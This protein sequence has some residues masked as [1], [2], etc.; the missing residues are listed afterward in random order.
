MQT[1][2]KP[3]VLAQRIPQQ[4]KL[5]KEW[6]VLCSRATSS[7]EE[8]EEEEEKEARWIAES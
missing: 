5:V 1:T 4:E 8:E 6:G 3:A 7:C 2:R